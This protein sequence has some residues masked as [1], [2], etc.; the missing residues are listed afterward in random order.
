[1]DL[2]KIFEVRN[3]SNL[4]SKIFSIDIIFGQNFCSASK[5]IF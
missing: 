2:E 5:E 3:G 4:V 1:M